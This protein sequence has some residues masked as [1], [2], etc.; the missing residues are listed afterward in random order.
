MIM[1]DTFFISQW[2]LQDQLLA[3]FLLLQCRHEGY[4]ATKLDHKG[5]WI[6]HWGFFS[7]NTKLNSHWGM[8]LQEKEEEN[9]EKDIHG[10]HWGINPPS[11][12]PPPSFLPSPPWINKLSKPPFLGNLPSILVFCDPPKSQTFQ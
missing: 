1:Q 8:D 9:N 7:L 5:K 6:T 10:G 11:K 4:L 3:A 2:H 12:T